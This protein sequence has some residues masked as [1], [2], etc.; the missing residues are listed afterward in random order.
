[1]DW[2]RMATEETPEFFRTMD[3]AEFL[4]RKVYRFFLK[5]QFEEKWSYIV[6]DGFDCYET[7]K[8]LVN[9]FIIGG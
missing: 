2:Q 1:M 4:G 3:G 9:S 7:E 6:E 8:E 5:T